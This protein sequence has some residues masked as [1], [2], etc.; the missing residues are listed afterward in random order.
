MADRTNDD[1]P[2]IF[3]ERLRGYGEKERVFDPF[4]LPITVFIC[5]ITVF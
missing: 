3:R 4:F 2:K 1:C 5:F